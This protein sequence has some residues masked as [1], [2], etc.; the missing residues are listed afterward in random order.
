[1]IQ[2]VLA[3]FDDKVAVN[4]GV[5]FVIGTQLCT[6]S[7]DT[8]I[9]GV[10]AAAVLFTGQSTGAGIGGPLLHDV[11]RGVR[12]KRLK[13]VVQVTT[14]CTG[15]TAT[16]QAQFI[17]SAAAALSAPTVLLSTAAIAVA[18]LVAG[19]RFRFGSLPGVVPQ[20]FVGI[21]YVVATANLTAGAFSSSL[22][23][24][25]DDHADILG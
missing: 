15:A 18:A 24:D 3:I 25:E 9:A 21:Q 6:N 8:S 10:P 1:M 17:C 20:E 13:I 11:G 19:Y 2:D 12:A 4:N 14:A 22:I 7:Y 23:L 16:V 5:T